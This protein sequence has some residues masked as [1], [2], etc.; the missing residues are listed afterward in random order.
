MS[1]ESVAWVTSKPDA[2][3]MRR[4]CSWLLT[5]SCRTISR[6]ADWRRAF[7]VSSRLSRQ[8]EQHNSKLDCL[9]IRMYK[10]S[11]AVDAKTMALST[12]LERDR[13]DDA[14]TRLARVAIAG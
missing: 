10:Y 13:A 9:Y 8:K 5:G 14:A 11:F 12:P 1:R 6:M 2:L 3:I 7:M 4:S